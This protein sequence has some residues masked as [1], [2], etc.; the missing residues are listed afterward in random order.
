MLIEILTEHKYNKSM[1]VMVDGIAPKGRAAVRPVIQLDQIPMPAER[2][3]PTRL[4]PM[5]DVLPPTRQATFAAPQ[6]GASSLAMA[7]P[8]TN[9]AIPLPIPARQPLPS[10]MWLLAGGASAAAL[11]GGAAGLTHVIS[12]RVQAQPV[13]AV[14]PAQAAVPSVAPTPPST[15]VPAPVAAAAPAI[16]VTSAQIQ[17]V[18]NGF[19]ASAGQ[20]VYAV[21]KD[22]KTG[23]LASVAPDQTIT[24]AS[25]YK[26]FVAQ[27]IYSLIDAGKLSLGSAVPGTGSN[28]SDCLNAM[29]TVSD[30][31]C[32]EAMEGMLGAS[33]YNQT[34][35]QYGFSHTQF[36]YPT[37]TSAGDVGLLLERLYSG[38]LLSPNSTDQFTNL[39]KSQ[40]VN[41]R[42]P[43]GLPA[44]TT[45]AHKTGDVLGFVH[46]AGIVYG[47]KTD[48]LVVIMTGP[49]PNPGVAPA[50]FA[51][52][53]S[54]LYQL[55]NQ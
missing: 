8:S 6:L 14:A 23:Q 31:T 49:W 5:F 13:A 25:L 11:I 41:N 52:V 33:H 2:R 15:P 47:P 54:Q 43:Q 40:R 19:A 9:P 46:D 45:I 36:T 22:L 18:L 53:S 21:V 55:F 20:P 38:T 7:W 17:S 27:G 12:S 39:L 1:S 29:I 51:D 26:L 10:I 32:G 50:K 48:Y 37:V 35:A 24:S 16:T 34:L 30:N 42:L 4:R 28:I 44:G 3:A